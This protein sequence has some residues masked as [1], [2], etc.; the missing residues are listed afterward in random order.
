MNGRVYDY[1]LGRFLS[2]DPIISNPANSQSINPYSYIGNNPLSGVDPTGYNS[3]RTIADPEGSVEDNN[4]SKIKE[5]KINGTFTAQTPLEQVANKL[6]VGV[7]SVMSALA[8]D[9]AEMK[10][11]FGLSNGTTLQGAETRSTV[12]EHQGGPQQTAA[13][14]NGPTLRAAP[15]ET[16]ADKIE[17]FLNY[18]FDGTNEDPLMAVYVKA[19]GKA[20][21]VSDDQLELLRV[22]AKPDPIEEV[23]NEARKAIGVLT[24]PFATAKGM[25]AAAEGIA[26]TSGLTILEREGNVVI[27]SFKGAA[28]EARVISEMVREGDTLIL[29][30]T[31]IEGRTTLKEAFNVAREFGRQQGAKTVIIEGGARTTGANPGHVPKPIRLETGL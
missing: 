7:P 21:G 22:L 27:G 30:G 4:I 13:T 16:L 18:F 12:P 3:T 11:V 20:G 24:L 2:V 26:A 5:G 14:Y 8:A 19:Y 6:G 9:A 17:K 15:G 23:A 31:H 28:G 25:N 10:A 1:R 29:R